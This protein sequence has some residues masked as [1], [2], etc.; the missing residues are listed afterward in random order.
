MN[1]L[2]KMVSI[3]PLLLLAAS[4]AGSPAVGRPSPLATFERPDDWFHA[5][6]AGE[7]V[8]ESGCLTIDGYLIVF[9]HGETSWNEG[10]KAV[11]L[12]GQTF[13]VGEQARLSGGWVESSSLPWTVLPSDQCSDFEVFAVGGPA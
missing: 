3:A 5:F 12:R 10:A 11:E 1:H 6:I 4:C 9:P 7:L 2:G 8:L 13:A